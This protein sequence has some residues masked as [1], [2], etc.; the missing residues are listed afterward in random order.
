[1]QSVRFSRHFV[2]FK[3][4]FCIFGIQE[5]DDHV[6]FTR[7]QN[8]TCDKASSQ[9]I[10][11]PEYCQEVLISI[12]VFISLDSK[13]ISSFIHDIIRT[14]YQSVCLAHQTKSDTNLQMKSVSY[15]NIIIAFRLGSWLDGW[16]CTRKKKT[17]GICKA[18]C[19]CSKMTTMTSAQRKKK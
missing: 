6:I 8:L 17:R 5:A 11:L 4:F 16:M 13:A 14:Y 1:M 2:N 10:V 3:S 19:A 15:A 7:V 12:D 18:A 9:K